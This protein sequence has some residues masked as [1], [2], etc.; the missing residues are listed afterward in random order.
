ME[1][2]GLFCQFSVSHTTRNPRG[3]E[4]EGVHYHF[5]DEQEFNKLEFYEKVQFTGNQYG[6][7]KNAI[8]TIIEKK[9]L[10]ILDVNIWAIAQLRE[11]DTLRMTKVFIKP[12]SL[13][14]LWERLRK[15]AKSTGESIA[16][17]KRRHAK[18]IEE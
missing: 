7:T 13:K 5:V 14:C 4:K 2:L 3:Q 6:T 10:P 12:P 15:R 1:E 9:K 18:A 17:S 11:H 16:S 8:R